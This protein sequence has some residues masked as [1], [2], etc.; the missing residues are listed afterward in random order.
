MT[1]KEKA[2]NLVTEFYS[3]DLSP[4]MS[5]SKSKQCALIAVTEILIQVAGTGKKTE[6][7]NYWSQVKEEIELL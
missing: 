7:S 6:G 2:K 4:C 3:V 5:W 1:A